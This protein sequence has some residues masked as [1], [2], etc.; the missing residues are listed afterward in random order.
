MIFLVTTLIILFVSNARNELR[1]SVSQAAQREA[2]F[3]AT[4]AINLVITQIRSATSMTSTG[5][6]SQPGAIRTWDKG[7]NFKAGYKLYSDEMMIELSERTLVQSD[8]ANLETWSTD[9][10]IYV[11]L[12]EPVIR[13]E[14]VTYPIVD[15][16]AKDTPEWA[17]PTE[18][19][20][21]GVEGFDYD[22]GSI[23]TSPK[24]KKLAALGATALPMPVRWI[25]QLKDGTLGVLDAKH[26][27]VPADKTK[28]IRP[29]RG[30]PIVSRFAFWTD[31]ETCKLNPNTHSGGNPATP[32]K[33]GG[34][35]DRILYRNLPERNEWQRYPGHPAST[36]LSPVF[37]PGW[38]ATYSLRRR[39]EMEAFSQLT[40]RVVGGGL[41]SYRQSDPF[42]DNGLIPDRDRLYASVDEL[43]FDPKRGLN[44]FPVPS[45]EPSQ[46]VLR[47]NDA[48]ELLERSRFF[49][50]VFSEAPETTLF[51][52]PRVSMWPTHH[53]EE[54][55]PSERHTNHDRML[56]F[57][58]ELGTID[59][60]EAA[61]HFYHFQRKNADSKT[62]DFEEIQRN[63]EL[64]EYLDRLTSRDVPGFGKNFRSKYGEQERLQ[65]LTEIFDYIRSTNLHD[66]NVHGVDWREELTTNN[67]SDHDTFTNGRFLFHE[68]NGTDTPSLIQDGRTAVEGIHKGHGQVTP[69][70][71]KHQGV[72][73]KGLGRFYTIQNVAVQV[74]ACADGADG[75][76]GGG[77]QPADPGT[78]EYQRGITIPP[79]G[80]R[81]SNFP[82]LP[83]QV[84]QDD[85]P[86]WPTWLRR[87]RE[88]S[89]EFVEMAFD[90]ENWNWQLAWLDP[91][92]EDAMPA[93]KFQQSSL[94]DPEI[95][96]LDAGEKLVQAALVWSMFS[97]SLGWTPI[98]P[99]MIL[100]FEIDG[101]D[102]VDAEGKPISFGWR[103][104]PV[105]GSAGP[106]STS[107]ATSRN[108]TS[109]RDFHFGGVKIPGF[110]QHA[111][112]ELP[113][114]RRFEFFERENSN[115]DHRP[116][117]RHEGPTSGRT[118]P[119]DLNF[120]NSKPYHRYHYIT[121]PFKVGSDV[122]MRSG[123]VNIR[124]FSSG[125]SSGNEFTEQTAAQV[126]NH[127]LVQSL[128][129][130]FPPFTLPAPELAPGAAQ[131]IDEFGASSPK[132]GKYG[133][134]HFWSLSWDGP[135]PL[136]ASIGR[137]AF[138]ESASFGSTLS[139]RILSD[140]ETFHF[141][142]N[143]SDVI[144][145]VGI[146]HS[147]GRMVSAKP[148]IKPEDEIFLPHRAYSRRRIAHEFHALNGGRYIRTQ[149]SPP[150]PLVSGIVYTYNKTPT[151]HTDDALEVQRY[152]DF[153]NGI[154]N[155][156]DGA[157]LNKPDE[158]V[159][160][161][162][163]NRS[164]LD[165]QPYFNWNNSP[166]RFDFPGPYW[167]IGS[168][169]YF[170]GLS[171]YWISYSH[172]EQVVPAYHTPNRFVSSPVMFGSLP[173]GTTSNEP[174]RTLLF[175]PN[176]DGGRYQSHPG[177]GDS[178]E[179]PDHLL[180]DLFWMPIV[181]PYAISE[182]L[183]TKGKVNLNY[184]IL[185]FRHIT[186]NTALRGI[187]K[188]ET[189]VCIPNR[190]A[191]DY[192][193]GFGRGKGYHW[194]D[195]PY[196]GSLQQKN[197]RTSIL[198]HETLAQFEERF[199]D[200]ENPT[201]FRSA[202]QI[203]EIPLVPVYLMKP[204]L[205]ED[206]DEMAKNGLRT[207]TPTVEQMKDGTY[208]SDHAVV[209]D[210]SREE[211][212]D[213]LYAKL[214]TKS[215]TY[216]VH[217]RAQSLKQRTRRDGDR[218]SGDVDWDP[219]TDRVLAESRGSAVIHRYLDANDPGIPDYATTPD[220]PPLGKFYRYRITQRTDTDS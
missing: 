185:P 214:T 204:I 77:W 140:L 188:A 79:S 97:P 34:V 105:F 15:P 136:H 89:P 107:W 156:M 65:I 207:Y 197:L 39:E 113:G 106:G 60:E 173:V 72:E 194:R 171:S 115:P 58:A 129:I 215:N 61:R 108:G 139:E 70:S 53:H 142:D 190:H 117:R 150:S 73:T 121:R 101:L 220:A 78:F 133:P 99:D 13:G 127:Q 169:P 212:Y 159:L 205:G 110:F 47:P 59:E 45:P 46:S 20:E 181:E 24:Q 95:T 8:F 135:N 41:L 149:E 9:P 56:R 21:A 96:R 166:N 94:G 82:P 143:S 68:V 75:K 80:K 44:P 132:Y 184:Q 195:N 189:M 162:L 151:I 19:D 98:N 62:V 92:Y 148:T 100:D 124:I 67:R 5:W 146:S 158:G 12:N 27:F 174:W 85:P 186:R 122:S 17:I 1:S 38:P 7:G 128:E 14:K 43:I 137:M 177:S 200:L 11:D 155:M 71:I 138:S 191:K 26:R 152:G 88:E 165:Y 93:A 84:T 120:A 6:A 112:R 42:F 213:N 203:C 206:Y 218:K 50:S 144:Q 66:D 199:E 16:T 54:D 161:N 180:L 123:Q 147:D 2:E 196:G 31:D 104:K 63:R 154:A 48:A 22:L 175:R 168:V 90:P 83:P 74:I 91:A 76:G 52:T 164:V 49:L 216:K 116:T 131:Y 183:S 179:L 64:Y 201:L 10:E 69:I 126:E 202:S 176:V 198:D 208:W 125:G 130:A 33:A 23:A 219:A 57:C 210:N 86:T 217:F 25:Y 192:K 109:P 209:G 29:S 37:L 28:G 51:E 178:G 193:V 3:A 111:G 30:N 36:Y 157:F 81:Y 103:K 119:L 170:R 55:E 172:P 145:S 32:P 134:M 87:L 114:E 118:T 182:T 40:P 153:D 18:H 141:P 163:E 187:F 102:F 4:D 211:P 160:H 35:W 167:R